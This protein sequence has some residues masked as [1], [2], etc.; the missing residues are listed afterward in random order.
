MQTGYRAFSRHVSFQKWNH[1]VELNWTSL[2]DITMLKASYLKGQNL[3]MHKK[4]LCLLK[5]N[6]LHV[7][8]R[9]FITLHRW[10]ELCKTLQ[11]SPCEG[12]LQKQQLLLRF[13]SVH[14]LIHISAYLG[15]VSG[16]PRLIG[17]QQAFLKDIRLKDLYLVVCQK[18]FFLV[19]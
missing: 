2:F 18:F 10:V 16:W 14:P 6:I 7:N 3:S 8:P 1:S 17:Q 13:V 9:I 15:A 19:M 4:C 11:L 12:K 5:M